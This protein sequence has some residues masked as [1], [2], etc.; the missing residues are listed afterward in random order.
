[1]IEAHREQDTMDR[2][3]PP[4]ILYPGITLS[5]LMA[6]LAVGQA[7][8]A[9]T[10][11]KVV[12]EG[13]VAAGREWKAAIGQGWVFR[14]V[15]IPPLEAGYSG[16]DLVV[17][18]D[19]PAGFPDALYLATPPYRSINEREIGTTYGLRAQDAI[20]WNPRSFHFLT[21]P[22]ALREAQIPYLAALEPH[23]DAVSPAG[24]S[25]ASARLLELAKGAAQG[26]FLVLDSHLSPGVADPAPYAERWAAAAARMQHEVE[27]NGAV[28]P[29]GA[30]TW[31][32]FRVTLWLPEHWILPREVRAAPSACG[33]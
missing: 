29:R 21:D 30:L 8:V 26:E 3:P 16:W 25:Q 19:K 5:V 4:R 20:G 2:N 12:L 27:T 33:K 17:D 24:V 13:D 9:Q 23:K 10:C 1:M 28:S 18:R 15:P 22:H 32:R 6:L 14:I 7:C 11:V 31:M